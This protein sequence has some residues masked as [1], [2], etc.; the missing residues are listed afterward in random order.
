MSQESDG[1]R[2]EM[3]ARADYHVQAQERAAA[4][5]SLKAQRLIDDFIARMREAGVPPQELKARPWSGSGRYPT[6][7]TGWY[8]RKDNSLGVGT[9]GSYYVL[10]VP[11]TFLGRWRTAT[12][13]PSA[14]SLQ[15]GRGGRDGE[16]MTLAALLQARLEWADVDPTDQTTW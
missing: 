5:E 4:A 14:P 15:V 11:Q 6:G 10:L 3:A 1:R 2:A 9:D 13:E 7:I 8:L 12:V 16:S